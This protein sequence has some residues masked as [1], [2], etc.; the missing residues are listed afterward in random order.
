[1]RRVF[2]SLVVVALAAAAAVASAA[3]A[4]SQAYT[5]SELRPQASVWSPSLGP[6]G[7]QQVFVVVRDQSANPVAQAAVLLMAHFPDGDRAVVMPQTDEHGISQLTLLYE[8]QPP[9]HG[10]PLEFWVVYGEL[11][12]TTRDS[13]RIWW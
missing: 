5:V 9:G 7:V 2:V 13:F 3:R 1:M 6:S 10:V 12:A 8:G 4:A 11:Q